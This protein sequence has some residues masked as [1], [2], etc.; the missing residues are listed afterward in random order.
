[1]KKIAEDI[2][3]LPMCTAPTPFSSTNDPEYQNFEKNEKNV[4]RYYPLI[5][6]VYYK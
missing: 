4:W 2:I 3:I 5:H 1:M 6:N